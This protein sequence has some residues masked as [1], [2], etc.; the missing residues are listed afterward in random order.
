MH[1]TLHVLMRSLL[2]A[3]RALV[4]VVVQETLQDHR[5]KEGWK[6]GKKCTSGAQVHQ[7]YQAIQKSANP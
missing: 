2:N 5:L 7:S 1:S 3:A 6:E 4:A